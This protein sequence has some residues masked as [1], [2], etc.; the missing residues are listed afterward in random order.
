MARR[1]RKKDAEAAEPDLSGGLKLT[2]HPRAQRS[3]G[4]VKGWGGLAGFVLGTLLALRTNLPLADATLR[5]LLVGIGA[6]LAAWAAAVVVW[7]QLARAELEEMRR[8]IAEAAAAA[9]AE[10]EARRAARAAEAAA[11]QE[12]A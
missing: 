1:R 5:G 4:V 3:I 2:D 7:R 11:N 9:E 12:T 6:Y 8:F 10:A